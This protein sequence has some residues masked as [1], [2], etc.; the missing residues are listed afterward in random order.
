MRASID[1]I[2]AILIAGPAAHADTPVKPEEGKFIMLIQEE[3]IGTATFTIKADGG[4]PLTP[5][6]PAGR[7]YR[8]IQ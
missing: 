2:A 3:E 7:T 5:K 8:S 1:G 4:E 6:F